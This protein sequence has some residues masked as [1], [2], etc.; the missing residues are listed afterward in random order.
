MDLGT[1][2]R[3]RQAASLGR[4]TANVRRG[5]GSLSIGR[6]DR[7]GRPDRSCGGL[8]RYPRTVPRVS[9]QRRR[10]VRTQR[11]RGRHCGSW[12][13]PAGACW[14]FRIGEAGSRLASARIPD[15]AGNALLVSQARGVLVPSESRGNVGIAVS[16]KP[17]DQH[18]TYAEAVESGSG[19]RILRI[20]GP[21]RG[22]RERTPSFAEHCGRRFLSHGRSP[23]G[24]ESPER[25]RPDAGRRLKVKVSRGPLQE[26]VRTGGPP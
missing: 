13:N 2:R 5:C 19:E 11:Q 6:A 20:I 4:Y 8:Y 17:L 3:Q 24:R 15:H 12:S 23:E 7:S 14:F 10:V 9:R 16:A 22:V 26:N 25:P 1:S 21:C 18:Q